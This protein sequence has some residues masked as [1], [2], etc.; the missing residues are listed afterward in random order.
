MCESTPTITACQG[1]R[2]GTSLE[3]GIIPRVFEPID[4]KQ[5]PDSFPTWTYTGSCMRKGCWTILCGKYN[6][7]GSC[8]WSEQLVAGIQMPDELPTDHEHRF[9]DRADQAYHVQLTVESISFGCL[10]F[11]GLTVNFYFCLIGCPL[12]KLHSKELSVLLLH[13]TFSLQNFRG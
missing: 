9:G 1:S 4:L 7:I 3:K 13:D 11:G 6:I 12:V 10:T 2:L 8:Y 5:H